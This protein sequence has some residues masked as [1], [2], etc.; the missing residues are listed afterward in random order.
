[1]PG[2]L[3]ERKLG[4]LTS[5]GDAPGMNAAIRSVYKAGRLE[6]FRV[7][8]IRD[9]VAG[10]VLALCSEDGEVVREISEDQVR[11]ILEKAGTILR[12]S[13]REEIRRAV[14]QWRPE[15]QWETGG[16]SV[17][18]FT[19]KEIEALQEAAVVT[20]QEYNLDAL[21]LIGGDATCQAAQ[22]LHDAF[23]RAAMVIPIVVIP[24][25]IDNNIAGTEVTIGYDTALNTAISAI[26]HL[27]ATAMAHDRVFVVEVMGDS[28]GR[29]ALDV[30]IGSG[31]EGVIIPE[32]G[33]DGIEEEL[34]RIKEELEHREQA[35]RRSGI[36]VVAEGVDMAACGA[37]ETERGLT[38]SAATVAQRLLRLLPS[39]SFR[40][41]V[42]GHL[43]RGGVPT[44]Q[45]RCMATEMGRQAISIVCSNAAAWGAPVLVGM[46]R[47]VL[48]PVEIPREVRRPVFREEWQNKLDLVKAML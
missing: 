23:L 29:L 7:H 34:E 13:R 16:Q 14:R 12:S 48:M 43:Q 30:A 3:K 41:L 22:L 19:K 27:R 2:V 26:D 5:G 21:V 36:V 17:G 31:A 6:G 37:T 25:S 10:L 15:T 4:I 28:V 40:V 18:G 39:R 9:G 33:S 44:A 46:N 45:T 1:M 47:G 8:G 11:L 24:A 35:G 38:P 32:M 20:V 42:I